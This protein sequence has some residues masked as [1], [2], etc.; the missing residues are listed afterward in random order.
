MPA[1]AERLVIAGKRLNL[2]VACQTSLK[3]KL[4]KGEG[5]KNKKI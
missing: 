2:S 5:L 4:A 1:Q 3:Q